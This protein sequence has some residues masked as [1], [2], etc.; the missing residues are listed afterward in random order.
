MSN[1]MLV[2]VCEKTTCC[3]RQLLAT[4]EFSLAVMSLC[5]LM[6]LVRCRDV[7]LYYDSSVASDVRCPF[8][9]HFAGYATSQLRQGYTCCPASQLRRLQSL[10]NA[11]T[12][13]IH[14]SSRYEHV[15]PMLRDLHW[16][17]SRECIDFK[18]AVLVYTDVRTAW[19]HGVCPTTSRVSPTPI[20]AVSGRR[21]PCS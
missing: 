8:A 19:R 3:L 15:T 17:R 10:L 2:F 4:W 20:V 9:G 11:A 7:L 21:H 5:G 18:L 1:E 12:R 16:L 13:L 6:C 14:R